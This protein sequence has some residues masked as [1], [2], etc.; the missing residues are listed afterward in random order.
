VTTSVGIAI[1]ASLARQSEAGSASTV[2]LYPTL[3]LSGPLGGGW[4]ADLVVAPEFYL[5]N[6]PDTLA[7]FVVDDP[8]GLV[9]AS[10]TSPAGVTFGVEVGATFDFGGN[11]LLIDE[12]R[13]GFVESERLGRLAF[14]TVGSA[15]TEYCVEAPGGSTNFEPDDLVS[16]GTCEGLSEEGTLLYRSPDLGAGWA[17]AAS[18]SSSSDSQLDP[19]LAS[20][21]ASAALL[22]AGSVGAT[23]LAASVG[24][25]RVFDITGAGYN[26]VG[27]L[28]ALQSGFTATRGAWTWGASGQV[29][30]LDAPGIDIQSVQLGAAYAASDRLTLSAG[31][32]FARLM[33]EDGLSD[34]GRRA[35][36]RSGGVTAEYVVVPDRLAFDAG[37]SVV[38][39]DFD[40]ERDVKFGVGVSITR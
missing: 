3:T 20:R 19:G 12:E 14:G 24:A 21:S 8:Y 35:N 15:V 23:E 28:L 32:A 31:A 11:D 29:F 33:A 7:G 36:E 18:Y 38:S 22:F 34:F 17:I 39:R 2:D 1:E 10:V 27:R 37:L 13:Y 16:F 9:T 26:G 25:E 30:D 40:P 5:S 6:A 4:T